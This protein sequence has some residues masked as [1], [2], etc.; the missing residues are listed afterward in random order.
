MSQTHL[1][2]GLP[3]AKHSERKRLQW[4]RLGELDEVP[5]FWQGL[6][7]TI[8]DGTFLSEF[9]AQIEVNESILRNWIRGNAA[10]EKEYIVAWREGK[11]ARVQRVLESTYK[12]A[13]QDNDAPVT[14]TEQLKAAEIILKSQDDSNA[15]T[16]V[17]DITINFVQ[18][19][20]GKTVE[21]EVLD[22]LP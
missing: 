18:A 3:I 9:A 5:E 7:A 11:R 17:G 15:P 22:R 12:I 10:R 1:E 20:D 16:Q 4:L 21:G 2:G 6:I 14:R 8:T 13:T 19:K